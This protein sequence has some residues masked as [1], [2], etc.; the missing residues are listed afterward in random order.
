MI[1]GRL[2]ALLG[3][4]MVSASLACRP[5]SADLDLVPEILPAT[6]A[7]A[8]PAADTSGEHA[9]YPPSPSELFIPPLPVPDNVRGFRLVAEYDVAP[10]GEAKLTGMSR[11]PNARY[12]ARLQA[13]LLKLRFRPGTTA[14]GTPARAIARVIYDF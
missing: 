1:S 7:A 4:S 8:R 10:S 14:N 9:T 6:V 12:N 3:I 11:S 13:E 5:S 2:G